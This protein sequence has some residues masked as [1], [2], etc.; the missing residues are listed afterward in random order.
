MIAQVAGVVEGADVAGVQ[1]AVG[2]DRPRRWPRGRRGSRASRSRRAPAARPP[3]SG[4]ASM[5]TSM[6]GIA[7]PLV[8]AT[9]S[10]GSPSRH[11]V[12]TTASV[13]P[14][15]VTTW[16][17]PS[18]S[19]DA[20][21]IRSM[22]TTGTTAAP[23]TARRSDDRSKSARVGRGQQRLVDRR[24]ARQH[25]DPLVL[26][27]PHRRVEVEGRDRVERAA[28]EQPDDDADL[29]AEGVEERVDH[30]VAVVLAH[31]AQL[32]P[33]P[34]DADGLAV[35]AH[36]A[37]GAPGGA[38]GEEDVGDVVGGDR[39]GARRASA[40]C[41]PASDA[42]GR[43]SRAAEVTIG[44]STPSVA[45]RRRPGRARGSRRATTTS[46][47]SVRSTHVGDLGAV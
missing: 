10:A 34:R 19:G 12:T 1:P 46:A 14:K 44:S 3:V 23:V 9:V 30:Q 11:M 17:M 6:P 8:V 25:G 43:R 29:V 18:P 16:S 47:A 28:G 20:A 39:V 37:L 4:W 2:V 21:R 32:G 5:R 22:R 35:G 27:Q 26:D 15:A 24:R 31:A 13:M 38:G 42:H 36:R 7:R 41:S 33:R 40:R 45:Q